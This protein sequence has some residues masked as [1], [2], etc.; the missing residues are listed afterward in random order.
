[1]SDMESI[2]I[3]PFKK[4]HKTDGE[5]LEYMFKTGLNKK[6]PELTKFLMRRIRN[7]SA[8]FELES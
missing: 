1:M 4:C 2:F 3:T 7:P 6:W 8:T 5:R